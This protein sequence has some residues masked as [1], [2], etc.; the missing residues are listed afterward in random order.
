MIEYYWLLIFFSFALLFVSVVNH[1]LLISLKI[2]KS[3]GVLEN[4][5]SKFFLKHFNI[6]VSFYESPLLLESFAIECSSKKEILV[7]IS[8]KLLLILS[9][10]DLKE[11]ISNFISLNNANSIYSSIVSRLWLGLFIFPYSVINIPTLFSSRRLYIFEKFFSLP[12]FYFSHVLINKFQYLNTDKKDLRLAFN[13]NSM[14]SKIDHNV[15]GPHLLFYFN[16]CYYRLLRD[17][18]IEN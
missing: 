12:I 17:S 8:E 5:V 4:S 16:S 1:L 7:I 11:I 18:N 6:K 9:E 10:E 3:R 14:I 13:K 2:R 15:L